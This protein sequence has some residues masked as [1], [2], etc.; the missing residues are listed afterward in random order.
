MK[1]RPP[2]PT[3]L[4]RFS[5]LLLP[6]R[7]LSPTCPVP[8]CSCVCVSP[9]LCLGLSVCPSFQPP[10]ALLCHLGPELR[11]PLF[12]RGAA[13]HLWRSEQGPAQGSPHIAN[14]PRRWLVG[15]GL[16]PGGCWGTEGTGS[17]GC[18]REDPDSSPGSPAMC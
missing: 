12:P 15:L 17:S 10:F 13:G 8:V 6:S 16:E 5:L 9:G 7:S 1:Q 14:A 4:L 18:G 2:H 3:L 11:C